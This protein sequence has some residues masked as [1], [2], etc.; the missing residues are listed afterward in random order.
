MFIIIDHTYS[1]TVLTPDVKS[2]TP[3]NPWLE[4][5]TYLPHPHFPSFAS[6]LHMFPTYSTPFLFFA[7]AS[8][9]RRTLVDPQ[10]ERFRSRVLSV[11]IQILNPPGS[12]LVSK[13]V[14][15]SKSCNK[16]THL[17]AGRV[18]RSIMSPPFGGGGR[19]RS[20]ESR[21]ESCLYYC[22]RLKS[23]GGYA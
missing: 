8:Q 13:K 9:E 21:T 16:R 6:T 23:S 19:R 15:R 3:A 22:W 17:L 18:E 11:D 14:T 4:H 2:Q 7:C 20:A 10:A 5:K 1:P 12:E